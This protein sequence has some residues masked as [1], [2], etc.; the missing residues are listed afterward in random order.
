VVA[1]KYKTFM[2]FNPD[3]HHR[4]SLRLQ[5][6]DYSQSGAYFVTVCIQHRVCLFGNISGNAIIPNDAGRMVDKWWNEL[7]NK[8][9]SINTDAFAIMPNH[10]HGI[11]AFV[12]ATLCGRPETTLHGRPEDGHPHRGA[13]TLGDMM[14]WF[15]TMTTNDYIRGVKEHHWTPFSGRLWQRNY[16]EH[17]VR[18]EEDLNNIRAYILNNPAGWDKD[19]ENPNAVGAAQSLP[20]KL[21]IRGGR[22]DDVHHTGK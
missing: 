9:P 3:I 5:N 16:Y 19:A 12:G 21:F 4:R 20:R 11:L 18:N 15:K 10:I 22:P 14:D 2:T 1:L 17:I 7:G 6:Y 8:F 13:P